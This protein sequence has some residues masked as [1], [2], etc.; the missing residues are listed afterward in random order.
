MNIFKLHSDYKDILKQNKTPLLVT[1]DETYNINTLA[2]KRLRFRPD[3]VT[4]LATFNGMPELICVFRDDIL[5]IVAEE[6]QRK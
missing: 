3:G 5:C 2:V 4:F 6:D 1:N